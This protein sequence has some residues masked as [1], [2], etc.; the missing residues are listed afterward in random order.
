MGI[1]LL[2]TKEL[3]KDGV[4]NDALTSIIGMGLNLGLTM[5]NIA[6][7]S[8]LWMQVGDLDRPL[9]E[10]ELYLA[11]NVPL[12][13]CEE[14]REKY[15]LGNKCF[16][17]HS[18]AQ[19]CN[20]N[21]EKERQA[22]VML[23]TKIPSKCRTM[24]P[25]NSEQQQYIIGRFSSYENIYD[26][27]ETDRVRIEH[28]NA[29]TYGIILH[30]VATKE[31]DPKIPLYKGMPLDRF[32]F[33]Y[34]VDHP[35]VCQEPAAMIRMRKR[36]ESLYARAEALAK[37]LNEKSEKEKTKLAKEAFEGFKPPAAPRKK[38]NAAEVETEP[39]ITAISPQTLPEPA[40][41]EGMFEPIPEPASET[42][43]SEW[44]ADAEEKEETIVL[45]TPPQEE[46][47]AKKEEITEETE[48]EQTKT[49]GEIPEE[50][51]VIYQIPTGDDYMPE[52]ETAEAAGEAAE[53]YDNSDDVIGWSCEAENADTY[54]DTPE[55]AQTG[56]EA[57]KSADKEDDE[58]EEDAGHDDE[59]K[60]ENPAPKAEEPKK[61]APP[62]DYI[63]EIRV[64]NKWLRDN[65]FRVMQPDEG[66]KLMK[67]Y[68]RSTSACSAVEAV[69]NATEKEWGFLLIFPEVKAEEIFDDCKGE[70]RLYVPEKSPLISKAV[71]EHLSVN[72]RDH[73][74]TG[75]MITTAALCNRLGFE[76]NNTC[77][78]IGW[79]SPEQTETVQPALINGT[80][81]NYLKRWES[82]RHAMN[83]PEDTYYERA[84]AK[85]LYISDFADYTGAFI[86]Y[87][88][89][90]GFVFGTRVRATREGMM[91]LNMFTM[92]E[93]TEKEWKDI[94]H[95]LIATFEEAGVF[96]KHSARVIGIDEKKRQL[97]LV[98]TADQYRPLHT[99][100]TRKM[101]AYLKKLPYKEKPSVRIEAQIL[102]TENAPQQEG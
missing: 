95:T 49:D 29:M 80:Y 87:R 66:F 28:L 75:H 4:T 67:A 77:P 15:G 88:A 48:E 90:R 83:N 93:C 71:R 96:N 89:G 7:M 51:P 2:C 31:A 45:E 21:I 20:E 12:L 81:L 13:T 14:V 86:R 17:C 76:L 36:I 91:R 78:V 37:T 32:M 58:T 59:D 26:E 22:L 101:Q 60:E 8:L 23:L 50:P 94:V 53:G 5:E 27:A 52:D 73:K 85:S 9:T 24:L 56:N 11:G 34:S 54:A 100:L 92:S 42:P 79:E 63:L 6:A 25:S 70:L 102:T 19:Y 55:D 61:E 1:E 33:T 62:V 97:S 35:D 99:V 16:M 65:G 18:C 38:K 98:V 3:F 41:E 47:G 84:L 57:E 72:K 69:F 46:D 82:I 68:I 64:E 44:S 40:E 39:D 30:M 10:E 43:A 74:V